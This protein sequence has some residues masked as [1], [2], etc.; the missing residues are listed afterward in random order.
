MVVFMSFVFG[1]LLA[2]LACVAFMLIRTFPN[3][4][5]RNALYRDAS[6]RDIL[7]GRLDKEFGPNESDHLISGFS[8]EVK[9]DGR[10]EFIPNKTVSRHSLRKA[11]E[12]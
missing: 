3:A 5:Q 6:P 1:I 8:F 10:V 4:E 7:N 2:F 12:L 11:A 9:S